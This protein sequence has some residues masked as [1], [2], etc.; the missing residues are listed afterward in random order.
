MKIGRIGLAA[1]QKSDW[2]RLKS[3]GLKQGSSSMNTQ[4]DFEELLRLLEKREP[5]ISTDEH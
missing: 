2:M 1:R 5:L 4:P 3:F